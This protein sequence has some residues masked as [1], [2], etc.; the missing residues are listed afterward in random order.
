MHDHSTPRQ[1]SPFQ[2]LKGK[3]MRKCINMTSLLPCIVKI[4]NCELLSIVKINSCNVWYLLL[5]LLINSPEYT[6]TVLVCEKCNS[7]AKNHFFCVLQCPIPHFVQLS[8]SWG[9]WNLE[10]NF[11]LWCSC[12]SETDYT[13]H[14]AIRT[15]FSVK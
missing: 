6:Q 11:I 5:T 14:R 1:N 9:S 8:S 7:A 3:Q 15:P 13:L 10:K 2:I 12:Q 4:P